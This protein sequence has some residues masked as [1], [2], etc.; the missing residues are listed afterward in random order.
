MPS[1]AVP[2]AVLAPPGGLEGPPRRPLGSLSELVKTMKSP[3]LGAAFFASFLVDLA[4]A[5]AGVAAGAG[6]LLP[7]FLPFL[8]ILW[9]V[10]DD[11]AV[12][13][14]RANQVGEAMGFGWCG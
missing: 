3:S 11:L 13:C 5:A 8:A 1:G 10:G 2:G 14:N 6:A 12:G 7:V 9:V 4:G